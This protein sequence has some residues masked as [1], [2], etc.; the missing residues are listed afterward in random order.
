YDRDRAGYGFGCG[1]RETIFKLWKIMDGH[2][3]FFEALAEFITQGHIVTIGRGNHD[4]ELFYVEVQAALAPKLRR[5]YKE[6]LTREHDLELT[7]KLARFD[8]ACRSDAI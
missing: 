2:W 6:K 3:Q 4:V 7:G 1:P 8:E 5:I